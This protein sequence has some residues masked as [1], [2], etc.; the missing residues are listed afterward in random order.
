MMPCGLV[1]GASGGGLYTEVNGEI[2]L[3]G[4]LSTVTADHT[5]NGIVPLA[6]LQE[7]L[8]NPER[9]THGFGGGNAHHEQTRVERS[10][11]AGH[12]AV[13]RSTATPGAALSR[14]PGRGRRTRARRDCL[15]GDREAAASDTAVEVI[16]RPRVSAD[17]TV[18]IDGGTPEHRQTVTD[19][20]DRYVSAGLVLPDLRVHIHAGVG[21]AA[22]EGFQGVFRAD[23]DVAVIDLC[24]PG[25][26]HALAPLG[27]AWERFNLDDRQRAEFERLTGLT[28][29]RSTDVVWRD[30]AAERAANVLAHG[31]LSTRLET[32]RYHARNFELFEALTGKVTPRLTEIEVPDTTVAPVDRQQRRLAAYSEWRNAHSW[33]AMPL[34]RGSQCGGNNEWAP[35]AASAPGNGWPRSRW[36]TDRRRQ[37]GHY[38]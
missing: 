6:S 34:E 32:A 18:V 9:Y 22:C 14:C 19:A 36:L 13:A 30:R 25:E 31:L 11:A 1:P 35:S 26:F 33:T 12:A 20:V 5:A 16:N 15:P 29:W 24:F 28:T 4:I 23:G 37:S 21:K 10:S 2:E 3:V 38:M 27:H 17:P 8:N 7:L